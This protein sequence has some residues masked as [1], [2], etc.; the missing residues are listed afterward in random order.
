MS[1]RCKLADLFAT[2]VRTS[3]EWKQRTRDNVSRGYNRLLIDIVAHLLAEVRKNELRE[4]NFFH[5]DVTLRG[6][7]P[8]AIILHRVKTRSFWQVSPRLAKRLAKISDNFRGIEERSGTFLS[9]ARSG[10]RYK[11]AEKFKR[12]ARNFSWERKFARACR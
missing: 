7:G 8:R 5:F 1:H 6:L 2:I 10:R 4:R 3:Q 11:T 12:A 9:I